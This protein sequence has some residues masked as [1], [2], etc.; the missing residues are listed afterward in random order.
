MSEDN[1]QITIGTDPEFMIVKSGTKEVVSAISIL[2]NHD[3]Y[4]PVEMEDGFKVY[5]DNTLIETNVPPAVSQTDFCEVLKKDFQLI[6]QQIGAEY[7]LAAL[8]AARFSEDECFHPDAI[9]AGCNPEFC[10]YKNEECFPPDFI[11]TFRSAGGHIHIGRTDFLEYDEFEDNGVFLIDN[12]NKTEV[13]RACDVCVG[14]PLVVLDNSEA[15]KERKRLYGKGGRFRPTPYGVEY[16]TPS[17]Y[18]LSSPDLAKLAYDLVHHALETVRAGELKSNVKVRA[19]I[20]NN[21]SDAASSLMKKYLT[22]E[23][24]NRINTMRD[25]SLGS[26]YTEW[27]IKI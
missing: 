6:A 19:V 25:V 22:A 11:D 12:K 24:I 18:W 20:D 1:F 9:L 17:N 8:A 10:A 13:I 2:E 15:S 26:M 7:E 5:Y 3:K 14:L 4:N 16:R 27:G 21:D 23:L